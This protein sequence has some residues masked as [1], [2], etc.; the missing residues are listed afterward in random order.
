VYYVGSNSAIW[1]WVYT[2][3]IPIWGDSELGGKAASSS[4][5]SV[6]RDASTG[7]QWVYYVGSNSAIW[8]WV[9]TASIPIWGD[10]EL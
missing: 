2:A 5:P 3:S 8:G 7:N 6:V 9:Y 1:G 10:S 4:S